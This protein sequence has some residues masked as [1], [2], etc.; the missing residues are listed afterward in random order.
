[1]YKKTSKKIHFLLDKAIY[2]SEREI[3]LIVKLNI[4]RISRE[5]FS[6]IKEENAVLTEDMITKIL[7]I[8]AVKNL[9][10]LRNNFLNIIAS[11]DY[12]YTSRYLAELLDINDC[13]FSADIILTLYK[14]GTTCYYDKILPFSENKENRYLYDKAQQYLRRVCSKDQL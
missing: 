7:Q 4:G 5:I 14:M 3:D 10:E 12:S 11:K 13:V 8:I 6:L 2:N 1:M 9:K